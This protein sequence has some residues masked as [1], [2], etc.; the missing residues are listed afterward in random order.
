MNERESSTHGM[1]HV[2]ICQEPQKTIDD[3]CTIEN[4][5]SLARGLSLS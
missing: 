5:D 4:F 1:L 3:S 2:F